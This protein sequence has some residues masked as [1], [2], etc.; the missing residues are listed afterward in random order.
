MGDVKK[1]LRDEYGITRKPITTRNPQANAMVERAH[2]TLHNLIRTKQVHH[3]KSVDLKDPWSGMLS[4][5]AFAMRATVHTTSRAT[6]SQLVFNRDAMHNVGFRADWKYIKDRKQKLILQN[7]KRENKTR[8]PHTY[9]VGDKVLVQQDP[10][11]KH[12]EDP[13]QGPYEIVQVYDNGTVK[14][15]QGTNNGGAVTQTWNIR[16]IIPYRD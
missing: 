16:A 15:R 3:S 14:L 11:R 12:G 5:C 4:A 1:L 6:P 13:Y 9:A 8:R 2:Q 10:N 7:N